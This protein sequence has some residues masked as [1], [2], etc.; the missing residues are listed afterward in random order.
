MTT[1][2]AAVSPPPSS[3]TSTNAAANTNAQL[4][5]LLSESCKE[6]EALRRELAAASKRVEKADRILAIFGQAS[7]GSN[8]SS[9]PNGTPLPEAATARL[10]CDYEARLERAEQARDEAEARKRVITDTW[11]QLDKYL[12]GIE[13]RAADARAGFARIVAE[14]GGQ[15]VLASIPVPGQQPVPPPPHASATFPTMPPPRHPRSPGSLAPRS[16]L[17]AHGSAA[18]SFPASLALPPPPNPHPGAR[19]RPRSDSVDASGY[20]P[21]LPGQPPTKKSRSERREERAMYTE[22]VRPPLPF[23]CSSI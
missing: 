15:L 12:A 19:V 2:N 8:A 13:F 6:I 14:G 21:S 1:N 17:R 11:A 10:V 9:S 5:T 3:A 16:A 7:A 22:S 18:T 20:G 4:A 23:C